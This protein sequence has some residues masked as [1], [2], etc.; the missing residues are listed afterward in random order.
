MFDQ[1]IASAFRNILLRLWP[2]HERECFTH[3]PRIVVDTNVLMGGLIAPKKASGRLLELWLDG[4]IEP[5]VSP[6]LLEEYRK[7]FSRMR[8]GSRREVARREAILERL[9]ASKHVLEV[10]PTRAVRVVPQC[11]ADDRLIECAVTGGARY[12][13]SQDHHLLEVGRFED[14][15]MVTAQ[16]FLAREFPDDARAGR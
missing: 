15:E 2:R 3:R 7:I 8:F 10:R 13:V 16:D 1:K 14:V 12:I 9:L 6:K 11:P 5:V 4:R